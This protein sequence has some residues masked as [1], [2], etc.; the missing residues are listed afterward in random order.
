MDTQSIDKLIDSEMEV[1]KEEVKINLA[2]VDDFIEDEKEILKIK[3]KKKTEKAHRKKGSKN[4][5]QINA[6][7]RV[8]PLS[9]EIGLS[10]SAHFPERVFDTRCSE[11]LE[12]TK[13]RTKRKRRNTKSS[14]DYISLNE[15]S[16]NIT[17]EEKNR[18]SYDKDT[19]IVSSKNNY[20]AQPMKLVLLNLM[21]E[22]EYP[23][24][25]YEK[26]FQSCEM[27]FW[28]KYISKKQKQLLLR[29]MAI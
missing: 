24:C 16:N 10:T 6:G 7:H 3:N 19:I 17:C 23:T 5:F 9:D 14:H 8:S 27:R 20:V 2:V 22:S 12:G 15:I 21:M 11:D 29:M 26:I 1:F 28:L 25:F 13:T 18:D 4:K